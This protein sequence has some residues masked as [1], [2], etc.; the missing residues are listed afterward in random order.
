MKLL[1]DA[2]KAFDALA[3]CSSILIITALQLPLQLSFED[4]DLSNMIQFTDDNG[5]W[6]QLSGSSLSSST[7]PSGAL[8]GTSYIYIEA[9]DF[10]NG[11]FARY[12]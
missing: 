6:T 2:K 11:D 9:S 12:M 10:G 8:E 5:D 7:G 3:I 4:A 1:D